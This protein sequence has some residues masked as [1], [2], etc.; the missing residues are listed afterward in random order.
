MNEAQERL[1]RL[2]QILNLGGH[3]REDVLREAEQAVARM[4]MNPY[5]QAA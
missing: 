1:R 3:V 5:D 4:H 2:L